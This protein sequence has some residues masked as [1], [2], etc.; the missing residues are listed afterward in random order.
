LTTEYSNFTHSL[1]GRITT[2]FIYKNYDLQSGW[3]LHC[4]YECY[5]F[6]WSFLPVLAYRL[7]VRIYEHVY[8]NCYM[9]HWADS[10]FIRTLSRCI[11]ILQYIPSNELELDCFQSDH[12]LVYPLSIC[13]VSSFCLWLIVILFYTKD[14]IFHLWN[15][16][17]STHWSA[18]H[19]SL[20]QSVSLR[21]WLFNY[22]YFFRS[23][24][25]LTDFHFLLYSIFSVISCD[26]Q[27]FHISFLFLM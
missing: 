13:F 24:T 26:T 8:F 3:I 2:T 21:K 7:Y 1:Q 10:V 5:K 25:V 14:L 16:F 15:S 22:L 19:F 23:S 4:A 27:G 11:I 12:Y 17:N 9:R 20:S 18:L 6:M